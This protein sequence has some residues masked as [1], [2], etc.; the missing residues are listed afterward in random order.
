VTA[1]TPEDG[2]VEAIENTP[3]GLGGS[4][5]V[6]VQWHPERTFDDSAVSRAL[7]ARFIAEAA[8]WVPRPTSAPA[9]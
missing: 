2:V 9:V 6:G 4:F 5:V 1:R 3:E 7:F 8:A